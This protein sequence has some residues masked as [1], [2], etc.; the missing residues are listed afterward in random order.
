M[1]L[2]IAT[3]TMY[4]VST[5]FAVFLLLVVFDGGVSGKQYIVRGTKAYAW[6]PFVSVAIPAYNE[7]DTLE[8]TID[9]V[10][11]LD[12]PH[13]QMEILVVND[14]STDRTGEVLE[15]LRKKHGDRYLRVVHHDVNK[16]K[17][18]A[19]NRALAMARGEIFICL[20]A[21]SFVKKD[22]LLKILP[23]FYGREYV[24]SVLPFMK[25]TETNNF[26]L[27][28]QWVEYLMNFFLKRILGNLDCIHV[29][30][31]PFGCYR[32]DV[33]R[34]VGGFDEH[35]L[36]EDLEMAIRLQ[37]YQYKII[38]LLDAE[39]L[40]VPPDTFKGFYL[41]R[42]RWYK[43]TLYNL[44]K[45]RHL[46]L[47]K[48]YGEFGMFHL[49]MVLTSALLSLA[50]AFLIVYQRFLQPAMTRLYDLSFI[51]FNVPLV[52]RLGAQRFHLLDLNYT[53]LY[54]T[55]LIF[56]FALVWIVGSHLYSRESYA[57]KGLVPSVFFLVVYPVVLSVIWLGVFVDLVRNKRQKW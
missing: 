35:N 49:P 39:V 54:L 22:A 12:Y 48:K 13:D 11:H 7:E 43:G 55:V 25:I 31:G 47:N 24:A 38:Q 19:L 56:A 28:I 10:L 26:M 50:F 2:E 27:K 23:Y 4:F 18:A 42:N 53:L 33:L 46:M 16:G 45:H 51:D 29:T 8:K 52:M 15:R 37:K 30:P 20:D 1:I 3:W 36:T 17:G 21:D 14:C 57:Q 44:Y 34:E 9:S 5:Y 40:T 6:R 32:R 41:Q